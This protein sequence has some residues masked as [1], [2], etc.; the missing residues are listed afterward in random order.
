MIYFD[1]AATG[2]FKPNSVFESVETALKYISANPGRS[3]HRLSIA[4]AKAVYECRETLAQFFQSSPERVVFTKNCTEALNLA[5]MGSLKIGGQVICSA[6]EHNSVLRPLFTLKEKG[7]IDVEVVFPEKNKCISQS[8]EEKITEKTYMIVCTAISNL[9]GEILPIKKIGK[10]ARKH[11]LLF[12]VD[13]AQGGG[14]IPLSLKDDN[15]NMLSLAGHKGLYGIMGTGALIFDENTNLSPLIC[16]GTGTESTNLL[17]PLSFPERLE[18]G[19]LNL[20][21]IMALNS[22]AKYVI[23][24]MSNFASHL[25]ESTERMI[26]AFKEIDKITVYSKPNPAGIVSFT[27]E[28]IPSSD[29]SDLLNSDYDIAVRGGLHCAPLAHK[30]FGTVNDGMV[31]ASFA[32]QNSFREIDYAIKVISTIAKG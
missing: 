29:L 11:N 20:P 19:T 4:G 1:N 28:D 6:Y 24:N 18:A 16:G 14:H 3:A 2:G 17:Q 27:V 23:N 10:I 12:L 8:I 7:L 32:V 9:T 30:I 15:I 31:R 21:G 5:I 22:G 25:I 26:S 13:G